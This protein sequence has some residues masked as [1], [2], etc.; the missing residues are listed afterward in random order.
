MITKFIF[1]YNK[2]K[3]L[4]YVFR[5]RIK[6]IYVGLE[7]NEKFIETRSESSGSVNYIARFLTSMTNV[8]ETEAYR[9]SIKSVNVNKEYRNSRMITEFKPS[10]IGKRIK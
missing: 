8:Y 9:S 4:Y 10:L 2:K 1:L 3:S 7:Q 6:S 5:G